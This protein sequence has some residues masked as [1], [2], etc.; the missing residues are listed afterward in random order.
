MT[1]MQVTTMNLKLTFYTNLS[2]YAHSYDK[3]Y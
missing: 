3:F 1:S 2:T